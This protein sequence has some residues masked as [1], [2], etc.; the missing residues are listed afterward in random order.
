MDALNMT[1]EKQFEYVNKTYGVPACLGRRVI[2]SGQPGTIVQGAGHYIRINLD[3]DK[4]CKVGNY[5]P[6]HEIEYLPEIKAVR[7]M[8]RSQKRYQRY[9]EYGE[10]FNSFLDFLRWDQAKSRVLL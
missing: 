9:L 5:H 2:A 3:K 7:K 6:T 4:P 8:T 10:G 1:P